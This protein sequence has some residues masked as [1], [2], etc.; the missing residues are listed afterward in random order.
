MWGAEQDLGISYIRN[1]IPE[2]DLSKSRAFVR[3]WFD[4]EFPSTVLAPLEE[5]AHLQ[6]SACAKSI[7]RAKAEGVALAVLVTHDWNVLL[8]R[9]HFLGLRHEESGW[10][11][12]LDAVLVHERGSDL[13]LTYSDKQVEVPN[14]YSQGSDTFP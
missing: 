13:V 5:A 6:L 10:P 4:G 8:L 14:V 2:I 7:H 11:D 3:R 9:E 12:F 1:W